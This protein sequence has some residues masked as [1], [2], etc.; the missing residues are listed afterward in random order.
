MTPLRHAASAGADPTTT[1]LL[2]ARKEHTIMHD[3]HAATPSNNLRRYLVYLGPL[4][5]AV[6]I[7]FH[8]MPGGDSP[9]EAVRSDVDVWLLVHIGQL[10]LTP[11]LFLAVWRLLDGLDST[12]ATVSRCALVVWTVF[13]SAYDAVQG[14]ATGILI[15]HASDLTADQQSAVGD[16]IDY[17]VL[18]SRLAGDISAIQMIAGAAWVTVAFAAAMALRHGG[19]RKATVIAA[20]IST[21]FSM[22][23][24]PASI[25]L[26]ALFIAGILKERQHSD[27]SQ[28]AITAKSAESMRTEPTAPP[29]LDR[30]VGGGDPRSRAT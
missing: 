13:F 3:H 12:A 18:D 29:L 20:V 17:L 25:G 1:S 26:V 11:F 24:T 22:H 21:V 14:I 5:W 8:P 19:A 4:V 27:L 15:E 2:T 28:V 16:T 9:Y 6:L 23:M 7:L 10:V 30:P